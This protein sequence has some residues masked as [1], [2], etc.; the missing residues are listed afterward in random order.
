M[1]IQRDKKDL[2][3]FGSLAKTS[4]R[5]LRRSS[6]STFEQDLAKR[7]EIEYQA[8]MKELLQEIDKLGERLSRS[9]TLNDLMIYKKM[10]KRFL[11]EAISQAYLLQQERGRSRRGRTMLLSIKTI[12]LE[13]EQII[14]DFI[15]KKKEPVEVL[16]TLDKI[17]G[18][19][20]DLMI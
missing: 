13:I 19:L 6:E 3:N 10:V 17:R 11:L 5:E 4:N 14:D 8:R 2:R 9:L 15:R 16:S 12:D 7:Q 1:K 18:M 20:V